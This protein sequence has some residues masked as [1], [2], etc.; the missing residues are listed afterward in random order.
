MRP[1]G[2]VLHAGDTPNM[3]QTTKIQWCDGTVNPT[4][5]CEGCE[6]WNRERGIKRCYAGVLHDRHGGRNPG[7]APVFEEVVP[8]P[9]RMAEAAKWG[10]L[11][12]RRR[13]DKPWLD[14]CA[15]LIFVSDMS[16]ALSASVSFEYLETEIIDTVTSA[17]GRRHSWLW[18]TKRL[19]RMAKFSAWLADHGIG[20]PSNLWVGTSITTGATTSRVRDLAKV[21]DKQTTRF[22]SV[23]PQ[24]EDVRL[25]TQLDK[26]DWLIQGGESGPQAEPFD[27]AWARRLRDDCVD[28]GTAYFLKQLGRHPVDD[29]Q[30]VKLRDGHGGDW[31]EWSAELRV[32]ELPAAARGAGAGSP[33]RG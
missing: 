8:F 5:G 18:L 26:V 25:R 28:K 16:D 30:P 23:E 14:G 33:S 9:G 10:D 7:F 29:G 31:D 22:L 2:R 21:G 4:M 12:G 20:W 15:R 17:T 3:G 24:S 27:L 1:R 6:L 32:R 19:A 13:R 11:R